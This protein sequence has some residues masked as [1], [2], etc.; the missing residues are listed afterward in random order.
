ME[1]IDETAKTVRQKMAFSGQNFWILDEIYIYFSI[2]NS[3][4]ILL[5]PSRIAPRDEF[6]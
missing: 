5:G 6:R 4:L 1:Q 2:C 3:N